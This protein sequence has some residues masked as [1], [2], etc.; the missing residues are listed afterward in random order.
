MTHN[1]ILKRGNL[2]QE[3]LRQKK[4]LYARSNSMTYMP[5]NLGSNLV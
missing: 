2:G 4:E 3:K 1:F 5:V